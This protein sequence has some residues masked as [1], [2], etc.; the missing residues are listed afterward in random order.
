[1]AGVFIAGVAALTE[2][3]SFGFAFGVLVVTALV[4]DCAVGLPRCRT[5][6]SG[7]FSSDDEA[8]GAGVCTL[9][10]EVSLPSVGR[11][12]VADVEGV[13]LFSVGRSG[14]LSSVVA[15][16]DGGG[17]LACEVSGPSVGREEVVDEVGEEFFSVGRSESSFDE[18]LLVVE[19]VVDPPE[20]DGA[21]SWPLLD[22]SGAEDPLPG[23]R[24]KTGGPES[25]L[26]PE[27]AFFFGCFAACSAIFT[28]NADCGFHVPSAT[29]FPLTC[30]GVVTVNH[31]VGSP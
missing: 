14:S 7:S 29:Q 21:L 8:G 23:A 19:G 22:E 27:D 1:M 16:G 4:F 25:S 20:D 6:R 15:A 12:D 9:A 24:R 11:E 3:A 5:G 2:V 13:E 30:S 28:S 17:A 31:P 10:C 18:E 26:I